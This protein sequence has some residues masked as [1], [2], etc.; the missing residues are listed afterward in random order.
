[1][2]FLK[3]QSLLAM[4]LRDKLKFFKFIF[5]YVVFSSVSYMCSFYCFQ[6]L[7]KRKKE[8]E[9]NKKKG[10]NFWSFGRNIFDVLK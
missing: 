8:K 2:I 6:E 7:K 3:L 4:E 1:M 9:K 5:V 10:N